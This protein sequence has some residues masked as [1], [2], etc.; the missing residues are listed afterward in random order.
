MVRV[1]YVGHF[2]DYH[3]EVGVADALE[4]RA[5]VDRYQF[6]NLSPEKFLEREY[7]ILLTTHPFGLPVEFLRRFR[8]VKVAHYFDL[9]TGWRDREKVYFPALKEFD[10]TLSTEGFDSST[11]EKQGINRRYFRQGY[12]PDW[13]F[14]VS[15]EP[16]HDVA[17]VGNAYG[18]R[19]S[20]FQELG[21]RYAF[22]QAG[23]NNLC[24]GIAHARVCASAKIMV[25][26]NATNAVPGYW[27][28]RIYLHLA[29]GAF[30]LHPYVPGIERYFT[31]GEHLALWRDKRE[32]FEKID[33]Y[34]ANPVERAQ[35][36]RAGRQLVS[37]RDTWGKRMEEFWAVLSESGLLP[38]R[39]SQ[40]VLAFS[41]GSSGNT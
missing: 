34:L 11:Y 39:T 5:T 14:P 1:G 22:I 20:L 13:Y 17:F 19:A 3:T 36:A 12:N 41:V 10:L 6:K 2:G 30:V 15:G 4:E 37:S 9:V 32:L 27:S 28:N 18:N 24:R 40:A 16:V 31:D 25:A 23:K 29:C 26:Q 7:D 21:R 35:I 33:H 8:G 38:T